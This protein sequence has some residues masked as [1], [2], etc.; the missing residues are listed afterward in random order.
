MK[1]LL[2]HYKISQGYFYSY[3]KCFFIGVLLNL[4]LAISALPSNAIAQNCTVSQV[5]QYI[6]VSRD[7]S[8]GQ[9]IIDPLVKSCGSTAIP[10]LINAL[11]TERNARVR[12][13]VATALGFIGGDAPINPL[14]DALKNDPDSTVR[15]KAA[16]ALGTIHASADVRV[17]LLN[18][19]AAVRLLIEKF[20][21]SDENIDVRQSTAVSLADIGDTSAIIPLMNLLRNKREPLDLRLVASQ[22]LARIMESTDTLATTLRQDLDLRTQ[23]WTVRALLEIKSPHALDLLTTNQT[24]V[25]RI[26]DDANQAG[27]IQSYDRTPVA[28]MKPGRQLPKRPIL[29]DFEWVNRYWARCR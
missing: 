14:M 13:I 29:C 21:Q 25:S 2:S 24:V 7:P 8:Q 16:D 11:Q 20:E 3:Y 26:L 15:S 22:S 23:Y 9:V 27:I 18:T 28:A 5:E 19:S 10:V 1:K 4:G 6:A 17:R 12:S